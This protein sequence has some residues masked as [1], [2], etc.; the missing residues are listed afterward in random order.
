[1][2]KCQQF[3]CR[4]A[5][6]PLDYDQV[7]GEMRDKTVVITGAFG[8]L[9]RAAAEAARERG[10]RVALLDVRTAPQSLT[11]PALAI[12][13]DLTDAATASRAMASV[14]AHTG[15]ID[16][17]LNIAGG[18][19]WETVADAASA[20]AWDRMFALNV[21]TALTATRAA[22][23]HLIEAGGAVVNV[24]A[25]GALRASAGMGA[26][27]ASK[28]GVMK[29]TESLAEELKGKVRV[30]A[31]LPSIIDTPQ[32]RKDMPKA[33]PSTWV[34]P[35]DLA[36]VMLFLASEDAR[37]VNGALVPVTGWM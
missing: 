17:L 15:S 31:V 28:Q 10:A 9:G 32:N 37:A 30:N 1:M 21:K 25:A 3:G 16:V 12:A 2:P 22:L 24:G 23:P 18:F 7:E 27:A 14:R 33:D 4:H 5:K 35:A 6:E 11:E 29:L 34:A 13:V 20:D 26:Y 19:V 8:V 36:K